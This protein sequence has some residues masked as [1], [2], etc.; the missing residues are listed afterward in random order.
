MTAPF[1][2]DGLRRWLLDYLVTTLGCDREQIDRGA[3]MHDLGVGSRDAVVLTGELSL[4]LGQTVSP[5][6]FWQYPTVNALA[7]YLTG[8]EVEPVGLTAPSPGAGFGDRE[9][10]AVIGVGCRFPGGVSGPDA[11]W[12][13]MSEGRSGVVQVPEGRWSSFEDGSAAQSSALA[14]TTRWGGYLDDVGAFDPEFF[15]ITT[16]EA[17][18]MDPQQRLLLE[19]TQE[20]LD[21]AGIPADAL[22]ETRTGVF[23]GAC[24]LDYWG[25]AMGDINGV[26]A[27]SGTGGALSIVANR[28]SYVFDLRGPSVTVD[29]AC[30][31]SLVAVHLACQSLRSG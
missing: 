28:L 1:D 25:Q 11:F 2:E 20:A 18:K 16:A 14:A 19:V 27:F 29:T 24:S 3:S 17:D 5:V 4:V 13:F 22:A 30:S 23:A 8:G 15:D 26:D 6:D 12:D 10:I 7:T 31:S 21:N 9:P